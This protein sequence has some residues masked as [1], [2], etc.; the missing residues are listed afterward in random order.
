MRQDIGRH[1]T[2]GVTDH[3]EAH[4]ADVNVDCL[5][6][7]SGF[8]GVYLL[9][10]LRKAGYSCK[11]FE[12]GADL[13]GIWHWNCYPGAR[14]DSQVP[15]YEYSIPEVWKD[16]TW[17]ES[18]PGWEELRA[19]F[20]HVDRVLEIRKDVEFETL[21]NGADYDPSSGK[22][23]VQTED[24]RTATCRF[25]LLAAGFAAKR[26]FPDWKGLDR[27][28]GEIHH[29]SFWPQ[30]G[31]DFTG[32]RIGVVGT[33]STGV[34]IAQEAAH[35]DIKSLKVFQ[36]TPNL[37]LPMCQRKLTKEEQNKEEYEQFFKDRMKTFAGFAFDFRQVDTF[38]DSP[39]EREAFYEKL[40]GQ[41]GFHFWLATY[42]DMLFD[43]KANRAAYNFWAKKT[44]AR[45]RDPRKRDILAPLEP[46]HAFG[47]KR[48]S[49]EQ[50]FY[51]QFNKEH[52]DVI[53]IKANP[54]KEV[55]P[56]GIVLED[57]TLHE[58]DIIAL[59]T[60]FDSV[61]GGMKNMGLRNIYGEYLNETWKTGTWSYLGMTCNGYPN[62]FFLY[63]AQG[64]TAFS[65]GPSSVEAQGDWIV[66]AIKKIKDEEI[67]SINP[68]KAAEEKWRQN[69]KDLSDKTLFPG[70]AS[71]YMGANV[72][73]KPREQLNYAGGLPLYE[74][75]IRSTLKTWDGFEV[76]AA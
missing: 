14:V 51:E 37:S 30:D 68:T 63:G 26:H 3:P 11:I 15:V 1:Q 49:L 38:D 56:E 33:G 9:H 31:V 23:R 13:G 18:Y 12:A 66:D 47:T 6:V 67:K 20:D 46:P 21:V 45:I 42:K 8:G 48:P 53:D 50:D 35:D 34:Q 62:M 44:R 76:A 24:G 28:K 75:E 32:K 29:S 19:Y 52:V 65:N 60:G 41:G 70:T 17:T 58:L 72:P 74:E 7:G 55:V 10:F 22:W 2:S 54:I 25:L 59:A 64:P 39:E 43:E 69:V 73:G 5:I 4:N 27:F 40:W 36:R 57:G 16:W 61:T 71:W